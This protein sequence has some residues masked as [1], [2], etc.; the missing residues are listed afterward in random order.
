MKITSNLPDTELEK[1]C[2]LAKA[3]GLHTNT[4][5]DDDGSLI[6]C[7]IWYENTQK[8]VYSLYTGPM[9]LAWLAIDWA[10]EIFKYTEVEETWTNWLMYESYLCMKKSSDE[11]MKVWLD[12]KLGFI[13]RSG[14]MSSTFNK[15]FFHGPGHGIGIMMRELN[16]AGVPFLIKSI[17]NEGFILEALQYTNAN[18]TIIF[19]MT[20]P[21]DA[22]NDI[23]NLSMPPLASALDHWHR[24]K[25]SLPSGIAANK[26]RVWIEPTNEIGSSMRPEWMGLFCYY[27]G[28]AALN[29]GYKVLIAGFNAG[30][31]EPEQWATN[32]E[33]FLTLCHRYPESV[34]VSLHEGK[35]GDMTIPAW[36]TTYTPWLIGRYKFLF[37][38]C[39]ILGIRNPTTVISEWAWHYNDMPNDNIAWADIEYLSEEYAKY[40]NI[41]GCCLWNLDP[42]WMSGRLAG[43]MQPY[44]KKITD[45]SLSQRW[46]NPSPIEPDNCEPNQ[47]NHTIH[48]IPQDTTLTELRELTERLH[49]T[50]SAFTYSHDIAHAVVFAGN[51]ESTVVIYEPTRWNFDVVGYFKNC[52]FNIDVVLM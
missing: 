35:L 8:W 14:N 50:R 47:I 18:H 27:L 23:P 33:S 16:T 13:Y 36:D 25:N 46:P 32:Y 45:Y 49:V 3:M 9:E 51:S 5:Y 2:V 42:T 44:I 22:P 37:D 43:R 40:P 10:T 38:A 28:K 26:E 52:G 4:L 20:S 12:E 6:A 41:L 48:L 15:V 24:V 31:P 7:Y 34:G 1:S 11:A 17:D 39:K 30:Q 19:R 21:G 29:D